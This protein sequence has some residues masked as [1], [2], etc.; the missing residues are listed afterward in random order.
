[1]PVSALKNQLFFLRPHPS[2]T[3]VVLRFWNSGS[4]A[5]TVETHPKGRR[6][7]EEQPCVRQDVSWDEEA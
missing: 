4:S 7:I 2:D 5:V 6:D 1:M 3:S